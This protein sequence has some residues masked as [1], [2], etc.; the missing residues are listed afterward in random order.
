M[1]DLFQG[2]LHIIPCPTPLYEMKN[3]RNV[4][5]CKPRIL[6]KRDDLT[7]VGL[8]GNKNRK[9]DYVMLEAVRAGADTVITWA[10]KQSNHCRQTLAFAN[11]LGIECHLILNG[12]DDTP[13]QGNLFVFDIFGA[14]LHFEPD[15]EK[16]PERCEMLAEQLRR[17]GKR[18]YIV[19]IGASTP[20]GSMGYVESTK[21]I[22]EQAA[23][24]GIKIG[25]IFV[26]S[27][28]GG[29]QAGIEV[30]ARLYLPGCRVHGVAVSRGRMEQS[31]KVAAITNGVFERLDIP[32]RVKA[33]DIL[34]HDE[35]FGGQYAVPTAAGN[36]A[37]RLVGK[38][39]AILLDPVYT[40]KAMSGLLDFLKAGRLDDS[41]AVVFVHTGGAPAIYN[42][43][44]SFR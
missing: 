28:S 32:D 26:G 1:K 3:L 15:E 21:E 43:T 20:L 13:H 24:M 30:G 18:P 4:V 42:F 38:A 12:S 6:I 41:E 22:A 39:E 36:D 19:P 29:T 8:G 7:E 9:L 25:H 16:C 44:E 37:I 35:Y 23:K 14:Q 33:S 27:G 34:V 10:G 5:G 31:E 11:K 40:G 17:E 2:K